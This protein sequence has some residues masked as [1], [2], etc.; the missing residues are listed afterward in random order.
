MVN[1][2]N[3]GTASYEYD[4][5]PKPPLQAGPSGA[6]APPEHQRDQP[7]GD[8]GVLLHR[9][10]CRGDG[11]ASRRGASAEPVARLGLR[12]LPNHLQV[13][14]HLPLVGRTKEEVDCANFK[15]RVHTRA[16]PAGES[17]EMRG[18]LRVG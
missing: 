8:R 10:V 5:L 12:H 7:R 1:I 17:E 2:Q 3:L 11:E 18:R 9:G 16:D 14:A 13:R 4:T 6:D 15:V